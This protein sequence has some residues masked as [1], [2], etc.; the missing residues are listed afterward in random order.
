MTMNSYIEISISDQKLYLYTNEKLS[1]T[2]S[3]STAKN[4]PGEMN[5]SECTPR[6][7]HVIFEKIG[8]GSQEGTVFVG[9]KPTGEIFNSSLASQYPQRDWILSRI[10][11]LAG[12]EP[13]RNQGGKVDSLERMIYIHGTPDETMMGIPGSHGCIRMKN[14]EIIRLFELVQEGTLVN[15]AE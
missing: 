1:K 4:G 9:R 3:V 10:I 6:G 7:R 11:R 15:I 2:F 5:G 8:H 14:E 12:D 13:G